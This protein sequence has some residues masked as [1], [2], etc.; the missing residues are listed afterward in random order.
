MK[1][2]AKAVD[3]SKVK[4]Q[5]VKEQRAFCLCRYREHLPTSTGMDAS[6]DVLQVRCFTTVANPVVNDLAMNFVSSYADESHKCQVPLI[7]EEQINGILNRRA[8]LQIENGGFRSCRFFAHT[9]Q[10]APQFIGS[11]FREH[12]HQTNVR[13]LIKDNYEEPLLFDHRGINI[14]LHT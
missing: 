7:T 14:L 2:R 8:K 11:F 3:F 9:F 4:G 12:F 13:Q 10:D 6:M 5:K 1:T